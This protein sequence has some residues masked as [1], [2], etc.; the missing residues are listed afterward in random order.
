MKA[1]V[2]SLCLSFSWG[3]PHDFH[4]KD[5]IYASDDLNKNIQWKG[6]GLMENYS[7]EI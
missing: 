1:L 7:E 4:M 2:F 6:S 5:S 3:F